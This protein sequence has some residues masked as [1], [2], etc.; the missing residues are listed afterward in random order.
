MKE[1]KQFEEWYDVAY[2]SDGVKLRYDH[3]EQLPFS[4]QWGVYLEFFDSVGIC[5][6]SVWRFDLGFGFILIDKYGHETHSYYDVKFNSICDAIF[7][8]TRTEAQKE[9]IKKAFEIL[10]KQK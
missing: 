10:N 1:N 5:I 7:W 9:A 4:M 3:F 2:S 6:D 8:D